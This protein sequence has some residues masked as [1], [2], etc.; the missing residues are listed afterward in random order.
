MVRT[1]CV[2]GDQD[3]EGGSAVGL[4]QPVRSGVAAGVRVG[5]ADEKQY[6]R[7][8]GRARPDGCDGGLPHAKNSSPQPIGQKARCPSG[9]L[10]NPSQIPPGRLEWIGKARLNSPLEMKTESKT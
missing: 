3:D 7:E 10:K 2:Y 4:S 1:E 8:G 6:A 9:S 5:T